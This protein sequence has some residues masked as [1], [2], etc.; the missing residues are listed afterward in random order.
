M[1][2]AMLLFAGILTAAVA[3]AQTVLSAD[4]AIL[5]DP[6]E[7]EPIQ[8]AARDLAADFAAVFGRSAS[9]VLDPAHAAATTIV[10]AFSHNLPVGVER[11]AGWE[12]ARLKAAANPWPGSPVRCAIVLTG[13][14]VRGVIYAIYEFSQRYLG[15]DPLY[16]WTDHAPPARERI[17]VPAN[18]D[19]R[20]GPPAFRY[21][22]WFMNDEDLMT[23]RRPGSQEGSGLS[24]ETWDRVFEALLRLKG[25][26]IIPNTFIFPDEPQVLAAAR[27]GLAIT[28][29]HMEPL[30]LNVYQW[31]DGKPYTL[32][33][34]TAAWKCA[35]SQYPRDIEIVWTVGLRGRYD[36]PFW[37]DTPQVP[38]TP[39]GKAKLIREAVDRQIAIVRQLWPHPN[40]MFVMNSWMEG[41]ALMREGLLKL[42]PEVTLVWADDGAG[43]LQDGG[44]ISRGQG[45]YYHTGVIGGN[46]NNFSERVPIERIY[47]ELGRAAKAGATAYMLLNPANIRPHVMSTRAVMEVAWNGPAGRA[48]DWLAN[49]SRVEFGGAA[50]AAAERCYRAYYEAPARYGERESETIAD[51]CYHQLGR[52]L[53]VRIMRRDQSMPVRF[54]FLKVS[55]YPGYIAHIANMCR[56]AEPRWEEAAR[57]ARQAW[58]L[59][60][61]ARRDFF[62]AHVVTQID[63]HWHSNRMLLHIAEAAAPGATAPSQQVNV[64]AAVREARAILAGLRQAECGKWAGFYTLGDWFVDIPLTLRLAEACLVQLRG[65]KLTPAQQA[66]LARAE[67]LLGEDTSHVYI[68]IKAY[69]KGRKAGFC[70]GD[71]P[72][73]F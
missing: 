43:L 48:G 28:Q 8:K 50:A 1:R 15:V 49:W 9:R 44:Q 58:P 5:I 38:A 21:R 6:R 13:S 23:A 39:E 19:L 70:A 59:I 31:P 3:Q 68:K 18:L 7:P 73:H 30:G 37:R 72:P 33:L 67:R 42:P 27:R 32:D 11:P 46:A 69:Q 57:L 24:L 52:D 2:I 60:A 14:D 65:Q 10:V 16:W 12:V 4:S 53:L 26:M 55:T 54:R 41:S 56:Q 45:V 66:T 62:L 36:R 64:E 71:K 29:H 17:L 51:D 35:V 61:P 20:Q 25:N 40:P 47:R 34:L 63:L 22:G